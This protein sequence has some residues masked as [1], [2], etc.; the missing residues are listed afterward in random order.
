MRFPV[1]LLA[2]RAT[3]YG[4]TAPATFLQLFS[5]YCCTMATDR[6]VCTVRL[7]VGLRARIQRVGALLLAITVA[8][9]GN[10]GAHRCGAVVQCLSWITG[11]I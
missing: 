9:S 3:V 10:R 5:F 2:F 6:A 8:T 4:D 7:P 1:N 11:P